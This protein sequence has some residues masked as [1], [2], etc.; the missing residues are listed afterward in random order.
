MAASK[1]RKKKPQP[2]SAPPPCIYEASLDSGPSGWI[3]RGAEIDLTAAIARRK[4]GDDVV[5]SGDVLRA[6][7]KLAWTIEAAV[8]KPTRPQEPH[9]SAGPH[10][11]PHFHQESREPGGHT[12]YETDN[13]QRK[14]R[15]PS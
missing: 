3:I 1:R 10:A 4:A 12:F 9:G 14:S 15:K 11:L 5:V 8:G 7:R 13:P 6:N 2:A